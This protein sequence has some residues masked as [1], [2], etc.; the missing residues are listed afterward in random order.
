MLKAEKIE[1]VFHQVYF[2]ITSVHLRYS[3]MRNKDRKEQYTFHT[4][5]ALGLYKYNIFPRKRG[6][7]FLLLFL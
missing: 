5:L 7:L 4:F 1:F 2:L 6:L 3:D